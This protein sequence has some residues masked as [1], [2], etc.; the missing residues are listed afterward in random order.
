MT[1]G[2][3]YWS[4]QAAENTIFIKGWLGIVTTALLSND[5]RKK[6]RRKKKKK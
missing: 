2:S 3:R 4:G 1:Q 6:E 5:T